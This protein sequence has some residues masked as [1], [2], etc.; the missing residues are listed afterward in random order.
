MVTIVTSLNS[1]N[2]LSER[3][4]NLFVCLADSLN[5][6]DGEGEP[7]VRRCDYK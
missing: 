4:L 1:T 3:R 5:D 7:P 2:K 6:S